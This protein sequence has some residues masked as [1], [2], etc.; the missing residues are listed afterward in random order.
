MP[1]Y[2]SIH[3]AERPTSA[4]VA[5]KTF[6]AQH[7]PIPPASSLKPNQVLFRTLYLSLD[8][9]MR[10]WLN[11]TRSYIPPVEI[12]AVMRGSG[13]GLIVASTSPRFPVGTYT[14]G[15][16]G[17]SEYAILD[18]KH[19]EALDLPAGAVPT[20]A[21][22]VLGMTGLTAYFGILD[23]GKVKK[24]DFVVV[25]GAAGATGSVVG[26]IAKIMGATV[27]GIAGEDSKVAW[28]KEELGFDE[29]L[30]YKDPEFAKKFRAATPDLVDV[31]F[32][33][34]GGEILDL[35]LSRAKPFARFVM[36]GAISEYN[37]SKPQG[38]KNYMMII[39]MRIRMQGF[40]VFDYASQYHAARAQ[41][42]Q[43]LSEG[44]LKRKETIVQGGIE[45]AAD[46]LVGL[47]EGR[48]TGK[49]MVKVAD[50]GEVASKL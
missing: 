41:L 11:P 24:G 20:D 35:A 7:H 45:K 19:V 36:C 1:T 14:T 27:L 23:V 6:T 22:G 40:I 47:F 46:A 17:W 26:Q 29:A 8:P 34:V 5:N 16:C 32:D 43:W 10:G 25:S 39:S 28:L 44:K 9:A 33:N 50:E 2:T 38:L 37:K 48:N 18:D 49:I 12:G 30:N 15:M 13:I 4:V 42:A 21:L 31:Y 3:L